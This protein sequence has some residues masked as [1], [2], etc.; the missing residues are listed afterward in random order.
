MHAKGY[1]SRQ[2]KN[3]QTLGS[4]YSML[5]RAVG[6]VRCFLRSLFDISTE[7]ASEYN[8]VFQNPSTL[9]ERLLD[10]KV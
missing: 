4:A 9:V 1:V 6:A 5:V 7:T 10:F 3:P 8:D 2:R